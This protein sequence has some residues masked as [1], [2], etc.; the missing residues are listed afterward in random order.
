MRWTSFWERVPRLELRLGR[1]YRLPAWTTLGR[2]GAISGAIVF[3]LDC[4]AA[5]ISAFLI[6]TVIAACVGSF[7]VWRAIGRCCCRT[8]SMEIE[9]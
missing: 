7:A 4:G 6:A 8:S 9:A 2:I 5:G 3:A 1:R